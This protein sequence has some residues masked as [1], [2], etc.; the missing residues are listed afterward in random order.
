MRLCL[1][2][3]FLQLVGCSATEPERNYYL[4]RH[5]QLASVDDPVPAQIGIGQ[6]TVASYI[7]GSG[8]VLEVMPGE[9]HHA[10]YHQWAEPLRESLRGYLAESLAAVSGKKVSSEASSSAVWLQRIDIRISEL[11]GDHLGHAKLVAYW[12]VTDIKK[13]KVTVEEEF[14]SRLPLANDGYGALVL[15]QK[16][17]LDQLADHIAKTL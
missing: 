12:R 14:N 16:Q 1:M 15:A 7:D 13:N 8:L 11:H 9:I 3:G 4:L 5:A 6:L 2:L 10:R 17:L